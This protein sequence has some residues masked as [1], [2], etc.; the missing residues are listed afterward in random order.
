MYLIEL[1]KKMEE[2]IDKSQQFIVLYYGFVTKNQ[3]FHVDKFYDVSAKIWGSAPLISGNGKNRFPNISPDT[4]FNITNYS[5]VPIECNNTININVN[6]N[7]SSE[8]SIIC[9]SQSFTLKTINES[10]FITSDCL[11]FTP[12]DKIIVP[13]TELVQCAPYQRTF[14]KARR[15]NSA[16][17]R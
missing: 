11:T 15:S 5:I 1:L 17:R 4:E 3:S 8:G 9:F 14:Q 6:G 13:E 12:S 16:Q 10:T 7:F 2:I